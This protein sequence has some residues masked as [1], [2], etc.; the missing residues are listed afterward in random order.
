MFKNTLITT[1]TLL[2]LNSLPLQAQHEQHQ[3]QPATDTTHQHHH[4]MMHNHQAGTDTTQANHNQH[5]SMMPGGMHNMPAMTHAFSRSLPMNRNGSGTAWNPDETPMYMYMK[6]AGNWNMMFHGSVYLRYTNQDLFNAG[7]RGDSKLDASNWFMAMIQRPVGKRGLFNFN[8]ML[9]LDPITE[10]KQ[11]YPLLFQSGETYKGQRLVDRQHPHDL[12]SE[13]S[14][15]YTHQVSP[16]V[17]V[18][19]YFGLP[20]EP[21]LGP[22]AFMHRI[23]SFNNPDAVLGHH[24]QDATHITFGVATLGV[25]Y[26]NWKLEGSSF[27]GREPNENRYGIDKPLFDSYSYRLSYN[28]TRSLALQVSRG[29]IHSPEALEP[30]TNVDRTTASILH[31]KMLG[32]R[33]HITSALVWGLNDAGHDHREHSVLAESNLQLNKTG[34][35]G[36]YEWI[37]KTPEELSLEQ[38]EHDEIFNVHALTLGVSRV[39]AQQWNTDLTIGVQG[40]V[41]APGNQLKPIYGKVPV[42]GE[43]YLRINPSLMRM[44]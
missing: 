14:V 5:S 8:A 10:G 13:L 33:K 32:D 6:H 35:Y 3:A 31:S 30:E 21:A 27:T 23:S 9:S 11:G 25:R 24:W 38:F 42:S 36:R 12:F 18:T 20:G 41:Y 19:A 2:A 28:P 22:V 37:Q 29:F 40:S 4:G 44:H 1:F 39:V 34:I 17:D 15:A 26:K 16:D 43:V 7:N